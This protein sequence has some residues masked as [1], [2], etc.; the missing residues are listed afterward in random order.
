MKQETSENT[1]TDNER[2]IFRGESFMLIKK[3][4]KIEHVKSFTD[5]KVLLQ[6]KF[7]SPIGTCE[8]TSKPTHLNE[9]TS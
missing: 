3:G 8:P 2:F 7:C 1:V 4:V 9:K 6:Q 5:K